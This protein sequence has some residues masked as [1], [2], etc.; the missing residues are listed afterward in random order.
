M[1]II[2]PAKTRV[3]IRAYVYQG[4]AG[5]RVLWYDGEK[6]RAYFVKDR[7]AANYLKARIKIG[8]SIP[9]NRWAVRA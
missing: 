7:S 1:A 5:Y 6:K 3:S 2:S 4:I 9:G 8:K